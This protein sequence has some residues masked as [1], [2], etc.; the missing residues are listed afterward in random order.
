MSY[1]AKI[2]VLPST[3]A[4]S[5]FGLFK[6]SQEF[7]HVQASFPIGLNTELTTATTANSGTVTS[8]VPFA[9]LQTSTNTAGSAII[10]TNNVVKYT[11]GQGVFAR[12][13]AIFTT[14]VANSQQNIGVGD[15]V[16]G[17]F[18]GF[19]G[20]AFGILHRKNSVDTWVAQASWNRDTL[21][22][23][24]PTK[25]N[26]Y[27]FAFQWLGGGP[28]K[29]YIETS[30]GINTLVHV[31]EYP[32]SNTTTSMLNPSLPMR[33]RVLNSGNNTNI[34]LKTPSM[35]ATT[36][37]PAHSVVLRGGHLNRKTGITTQLNIITIRNKATFG[38]NTNKVRV[39]IEN[40]ASAI[41]T[42]ADANVVVIKNTMLGGSP[43]Y[44]DHDTNTSIVE[45]D[46]AGTTCTGGLIV[47]AFGM[48]GN[49]DV[50]MDGQDIILHP[51]ET[52]TLAVTSNGGGLTANCAFN[53]NEHW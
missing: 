30:A 23:L 20:T 19:N 12:A 11:P 25:L 45:Y 50:V 13:T 21:A 34:T 7:T 40:I 22:T 36:E 31:I 41:T 47:R 39:H 15:A 18:F 24:D 48:L 29:F 3:E 1:F 52:L 37:A 33:A 51:S 49:S 9:V 8:T 27:S 6:V 46:T 26:V 42:A 44:T 4:E 10:Q 35:A 16:D 2:K 5:A 28:L 53:W 43:S 38:G 17:I 14:G 32:N